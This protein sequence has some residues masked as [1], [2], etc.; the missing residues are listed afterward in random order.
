MKKWLLA[1]RNEK[2]YYI[3]GLKVEDIFALS[4]IFL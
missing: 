1:K 2:K 3:N 4:P